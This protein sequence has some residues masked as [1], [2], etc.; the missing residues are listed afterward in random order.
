MRSGCS[1]RGILDS[2]LLSSLSQFSHRPAL[3]LSD[4][5]FGYAHRG[6]D[7]LQRQTFLAAD[8]AKTT[9]DNLLLPLVES[10]ED[11]LHMRLPL[12]VSQLLFVVV[13]ARVLGGAEN[14]SVA[15]A[16]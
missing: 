4:P 13:R 8:E 2:I 15:G 1:S 10:L 12:D 7:L 3:D 14:L 5:L 11:P 16:E 6:C 9:C